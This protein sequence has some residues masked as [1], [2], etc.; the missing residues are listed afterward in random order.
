MRNIRIE[1]S[2]CIWWAVL[3]LILPLRWLVAAVIAGVFHECCHYLAIRAVGGK[4]EEIVFRHTGACMT[5]APLEPWQELICS[6]AGP[7]GSL[8]LIPFARFAPLTAV[9]ALVQTTFN[10]LPV[11]PLDGG[12]A[13][14][15]ALKILC[16]DRNPDKICHRVGIFCIAVLIVLI[17]LASRIFSLGFGV[18]IPLAIL[19]QRFFPGKRPCK[20][21]RLALQ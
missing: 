4:V 2:A 11:F 18:L 14:Y 3:L 5:A 9:C 19:V 8:V 17:I 21:V 20:T 12:R 10:L 15:S 16:P 7:I 13:M 1:S 6:L